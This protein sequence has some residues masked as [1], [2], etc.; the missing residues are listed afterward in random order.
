VGNDDG[1]RPVAAFAAFLLFAFSAFA[2]LAGFF[3]RTF[4]G[5][6]CIVAFMAFMGLEFISVRL[7]L[8]VS[9]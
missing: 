2:L 8:A 9:S 4:I 6:G 7:L 1:V 3:L 5:M